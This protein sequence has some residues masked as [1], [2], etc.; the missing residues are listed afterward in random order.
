MNEDEG[1][2]L[3]SLVLFHQAR[4]NLSRKPNCW[5]Q[6]FFCLVLWQLDRNGVM[7]SSSKWMTVN[8]S[9]TSNLFSEPPHNVEAKYECLHGISV[10]EP[11]SLPTGSES[12]PIQAPQTPLTSTP[13]LFRLGY[14][15]YHRVLLV[16]LYSFSQSRLILSILWILCC[17]V[18]DW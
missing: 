9:R 11:D 3:F 18:T 15:I 8:F 13:W 14:C 1:S 10:P 7:S 6:C 4:D 12:S 2:L 16:G 5:A 17:H